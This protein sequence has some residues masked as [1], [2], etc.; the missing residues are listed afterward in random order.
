MSLKIQRYTQGKEDKEIFASV[1]SWL[2]SIEIQKILGS[3]ITS[4]SGDVWYIAYL[5]NIPIGFGVTREAKSNNS[6]HV[7]YVYSDDLTKKVILNRIIKDAEECKNKTLW[8]N[9]RE[10]K[11]WDE[12]GF[13]FTKKNK[14]SFGKYEKVI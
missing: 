14:G 11:I 3:A 6:I 4:R 5:N 13:I 2:T 12:L 9:E 8:T 1:G 10:N 7:R